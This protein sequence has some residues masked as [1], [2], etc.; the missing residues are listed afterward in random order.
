MTVIAA[1]FFAQ[2]ASA[3]PFDLAWRWQEGESRTWYVESATVWP[4]PTWLIAERQLEVRA[5]Q[6]EVKLITTCAP[7]LTTRKKWEIE[8][9]IDDVGLIGLPLREDDAEDLA[10]ILTE[11]DAK[12]TGQTFQVIQRFDGRVVGID[13]EGVD[14]ANRRQAAIYSFLRS[15]V[16]RAYFGLDLQLNKPIEGVWVQQT[17]RLVEFGDTWGMTSVRASDAGMGDNSP[18]YGARPVA[19]IGSVPIAHRIHKDFAAT[20]FVKSYGQGTIG[21]DFDIDLRSDWRFRKDLGVVEARTWQV[22]GVERQRTGNRPPYANTGYMSLVTDP[23]QYDVGATGLWTDAAVRDQ[24][25]SL[26]DELI[27]KYMSER[28]Y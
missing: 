3:T 14:K 25:V 26:M 6:I 27:Y 17:T 20:T 10:A 7:V 19:N 9:R 13:L 21:E 15:L 24:A 1:L 2:T 5:T 23:S 16:G 4:W 8:C 18:T 12:L 22:L 11:Y 28:T